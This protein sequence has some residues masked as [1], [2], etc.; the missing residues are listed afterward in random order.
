MVFGI[1][2]PFLKSTNTAGN[3]LLETCVFGSLWVAAAPYLSRFPLLDISSTSYSRLT[4]YEWRFLCWTMNYLLGVFSSTKLS[5]Q[6]KVLAVLFYRRLNTFPAEYCRSLFYARVGR[7][8]CTIR[9]LSAEC[10]DSSCMRHKRALCILWYV[11]YYVRVLCQQADNFDTRCYT[12]RISLEPEQNCP[13]YQVI[14]RTDRIYLLWRQT[15]QQME[16][17]SNGKYSLWNQLA[18]PSTVE[19]RSRDGS[20]LSTASW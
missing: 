14:I 11:G 13:G 20:P 7:K 9:K 15:F 17:K 2:L 6:R 18:Y 3:V 19:M 1:F 10:C 12:D 5:K 8:S 4:D 16:Y